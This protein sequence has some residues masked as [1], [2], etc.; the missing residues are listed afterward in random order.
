M[1]SEATL[2]YGSKL[3]LGD[4]GEPES[5]TAIAEVKTV[6]PPDQQA[7]DVEVTNMDSPGRRKEYI[8]GM[9]EGGEASFSGNFLPTNPTQDASTGLIALHASGEKRNWQIVFS[10]AAA[11]TVTFEAYVKSFKPDMGDVGSPLG[12]SCTLKVTGDPVWE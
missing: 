12:F 2:V 7:D 11:T 6:D 8:P 9:I 4:G 1:S 5:F 10:D 3:K